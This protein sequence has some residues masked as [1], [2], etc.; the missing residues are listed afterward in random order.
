MIRKRILIGPE[1]PDLGTL[2]LVVARLATTSPTSRSS[3]W[4]V[5]LA[6]DLDIDTAEAVLVN[7]VPPH[8]FDP[9]LGERV[10]RIRE[11]VGFLPGTGDLRSQAIDCDILLLWEI[12]SGR[13]R[14]MESDRQGLPPEPD[15]VRRRLAGNTWR[16][17]LVRRS[18]DAARE[19]LS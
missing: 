19:G 18:S 5:A 2:T 11:S 6:A 17:H 14:A 4:L 9:T 13:A 3:A 10:I 7:F 12:G 16:R 15:A 1:V 8:G